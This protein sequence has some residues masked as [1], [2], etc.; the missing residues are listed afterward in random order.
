MSIKDSFID[1]I[2]HKGDIVL[3]IMDI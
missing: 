1:I 3:S 2:K